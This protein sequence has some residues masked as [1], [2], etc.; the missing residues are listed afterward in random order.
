MHEMMKTNSISRGDEKLPRILLVED[1]E[2]NREVMEFFLEDVYLVDYTR[3]TNDTIEKV[4]TNKY[5]AILMDINLG[6]NDMDGLQLTREIRKQPGY[7]LVP[8]IAVT[9]YPTPSVKKEAYKSGICCVLA[10]PVF[11]GQVL[12]VLQKEIQTP[13]T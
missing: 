9:A 8:V 4:L 11:R 3:T 2:V 10:K 13:S 6:E 5:D 7:E 1:S 12:K